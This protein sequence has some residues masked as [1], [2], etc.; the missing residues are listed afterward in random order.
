MLY[1]SICETLEELQLQLTF[2]Q[3]YQLADTFVKYI[4]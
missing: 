4:I 3:N 1:N 2:C